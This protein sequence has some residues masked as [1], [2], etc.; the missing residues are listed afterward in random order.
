MR[1]SPVARDGVHLVW[2]GAARGLT[3]T[4]GPG[5][6]AVFA[7]ADAPPRVKGGRGAWTDLAAAADRALVGATLERVCAGTRPAALVFEFAGGARLALLVRG[8]AAVLRLDVPGEAPR[9]LPGGAGPH[10]EVPAQLAE[11][12]D[13]TDDDAAR[14]GL[15]EDLAAW[16]AAA[17]A[18]A[19]LE[20]RRDA[21]RRGI[22][23]EAARV[24][25]AQAA[26]AREEAGAPEP[27]LLRR[28]AEALLAAGPR[29][30]P[31]P[32]G[33]F[34]VE[35][36]YAPGTRFAIPA[37]PPGGRA[38]E[39]AERL[40]G[41]ARKQERGR[42]VR[43]A[44]TRE[45]GERGVA[46]AALG[47]RAAT[48]ESLE[49]IEAGEVAARTLGLGLGLGRA[50]GGPRAPGAGPPRRAAG[51]ESG[52]PRAFRSPNGFEVLA[53][54]SAAQNDR[55]TFAVAGPDDLWLHV[56]GHAGAHVVMRLGGRRPEPEDERYAARIA[57]SLSQ[58]PPGE[59]VDVHLAARKHVR[60]PKGAAAGAV[61]VTKG[62]VIRVRVEPPPKG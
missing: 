23:R 45:L 47:D 10:A 53:G 4:T 44:R 20:A 12:G 61:T 48:A 55:L 39:T 28:R 30:L 29:A 57:A 24:A 15:P 59:T 56:K 22:E 54:R 14:A 35:D 11:F 16:H 2:A 32:D 8:N 26:I 17:A 7:S 52:A 19:L 18:A 36:P 42:T 50:A 21:L 33:T 62:R 1:V 9:G 27:Q 31:G 6:P 41:R 58:A 25:R 5:I 34:D 60:K 49:E 51:E 46:L 43:A 3:V 37:D 38:H 40:F 13:V